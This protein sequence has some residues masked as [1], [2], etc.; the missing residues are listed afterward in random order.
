VAFNA[1]DADVAIDA[2]PTLIL[3]VC[4]FNTNAVLSNPSNKLAFEAE[5]AFNAYDAL[6]AV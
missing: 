5:V 3:A 1:Y 2:V 4:E 6:I